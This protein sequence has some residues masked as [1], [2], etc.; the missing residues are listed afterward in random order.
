MT[1]ISMIVILVFLLSQIVI[2]MNV[3]PVFLTD[4]SVASIMEDLPNDSKAIGASPKE[5]KRLI[6]NRLNINSVYTIKE[7]YIKVK[8]GRNEVIATI[9]YEP[10]GTLIGDLDYIV[11]FHHEARIPGR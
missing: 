11:T 5:I 8:K 6:I 10:R 1:M 3:V 2:A 7:E 9:D 4:S